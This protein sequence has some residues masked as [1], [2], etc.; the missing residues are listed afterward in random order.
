MALFV[1]VGVGVR[2]GVGFGDLNVGLMVRF[3]LGLTL[4]VRHIYIRLL[5]ILI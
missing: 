5:S 2:V 4:Q 3:L 1:G